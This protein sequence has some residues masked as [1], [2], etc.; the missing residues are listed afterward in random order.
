MGMFDSL[1][2]YTELPLNKKEQK[3][4]SNVNWEDR[5]FQTK[6]LDCTLSHYAITKNGILSFEKIDGEWVRT[7]TKEEE[8]KARRGGKFVW[9]HKFIEK[10]RKF[11]KQ[12]FDGNVSFYDSVLDIAGNEWWVEFSANFINGKLQ[13]KIKKVEIRLS[14]TAKQIKKRNDEWEARL[15]ADKKKLHNSFRKF[16][17]KITFNYWR[18]TWWSVGKAIRNFSNII[19]KFDIIINRYIA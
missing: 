12:K 1:H 10:S 11:V 17:N 14:E 6:D 7:M 13:G 3:M 19:S 4:F 5:D 8:K 18:F 16:M 9:P 15:E 2:V